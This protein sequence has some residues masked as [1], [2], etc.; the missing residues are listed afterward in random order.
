MQDHV[1]YDSVQ[2]DSRFCRIKAWKCA[3]CSPAPPSTSVQ[4]KIWLGKWVSLNF[5]GFLKNSAFL[6]L[7]ALHQATPIAQ[8]GQLAPVSQAIQFHMTGKS[9]K[10]FR[11]IHITKNLEWFLP[12]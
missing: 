2:T 11:Y 3:T 1:I 5:C 12:Q 9:D 10:G 8:D 7:G 6:N 4:R